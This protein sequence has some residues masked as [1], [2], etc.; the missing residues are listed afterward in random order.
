VI[1]HNKGSYHNQ[2]ITIESPK[3]VQIISKNTKFVVAL[4]E[5]FIKNNFT[6]LTPFNRIKQ[7]GFW[8]YLVVRESQRTNQT[9]VMVVCKTQGVEPD[10][11]QKVQQEL[12]EYMKKSLRGLVGLCFLDYNGESDSV[13]SEK[14]TLLYGLPYYQETIFN[15]TFQVSPGA[16]L[17]IHMDMCEV[18][19]SQIIQAVKDCD[20]VL[21]LGC[22]IGTIGISV[23]DKLP[24]VKVIGV[25]IC[26]EAVEDAKKNS[27]TYE[28]HLGRAEDLIKDICDKYRGNKIV[29]ILDPP[30]LV[31]TRK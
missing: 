25:E 19:Y 17:Q 8:R 3:N 11:L 13:P 20:V 2:T 21:D 30:D 27:E 18:L 14:P 28:V 23:Q 7:I 5:H 22:G 6:E 9:L 29:A 10:L 1:G 4:I 24:N 15:R 31:S 26:A 12:V 16:F